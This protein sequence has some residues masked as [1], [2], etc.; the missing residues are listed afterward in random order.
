MSTLSP[1]RSFSGDGGITATWGVRFP[2][3][4]GHPNVGPLNINEPQ[5]EEQTQKILGN[6]AN[7]GTTNT[8][9]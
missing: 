8:L 5:A 4:S 9:K 6:L 1:I 2:G 3:E 7:T